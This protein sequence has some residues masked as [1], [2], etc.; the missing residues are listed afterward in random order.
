MA[1]FDIDVDIDGA[2]QAQTT[3]EYS[4]KFLSDS[5]EQKA[6]DEFSNAV[7]DIV[8]AVIDNDLVESGNLANS[9]RFTTSIGGETKITS[10]ADYATYHEFGTEGGYQITPDE[11]EL[12]KID[13]ADGTTYALSVT[14]PGVPETNY[15]SQGLGD[16]M[17]NLK[18][19]KTMGRHAGKKLLSFGWEPE[20]GGI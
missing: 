7:G 8:D 9:F 18:V 14:H 6:E 12:L 20:T 10:S 19:R 16:W 15:I 17:I 3:L 1:S 4:Q 11:A 2:K 13:D 5:F